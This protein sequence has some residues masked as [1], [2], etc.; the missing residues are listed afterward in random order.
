MPKLTN[1]IFDF[2]SFTLRSKSCLTRQHHP[3]HRGDDREQ[4]ARARQAAEALFT[5]KSPE[6][7]H[8]V[9]DAAPADSP[10]RKPRV[11]QIT[12]ALP[13]RAEEPNATVGSEPR[14]IR[15]ISESHFSRIRTWVKYGMAVRQVAELYGTDIDEIERIIRKP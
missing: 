3:Q 13:K 14:P 4:I 6:T 2:T 8:S 12:A 1:S 5:S 10:A 9:P 15:K 7:R 11:P